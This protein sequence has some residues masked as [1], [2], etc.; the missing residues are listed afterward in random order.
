MTRPLDRHL[1]GDEV[2]ALVTSQATGVPVAGQLSEGAIREAQRHVEACQDCDRKVQMHRSVQKVIS[3]RAMGDQKAKG[4]NCSDESEWV[5]VA[6]GLF[7]E[8]EAKERMNHAAQCGH[9]GPLLKFAVKALSDETTPDEEV[10]LANLGS[11]GPEW[12]AQIA[13]TLR[14]AAESQRLQEPSLPFWKS[15]SYWPRPA[16]AAAALVILAAG[17][18]VGVRILHPP[19]AEQLLAQAYSERRTLEVRI[20]GAKYAPVRTERGNGQSNL[21]RPRSLLRAEDLI[22]ENLGKHPDDPYWLQAKGRADL[23]DGN[24]DSAIESL[25]KVADMRP[26]SPSAMIDLASA[27][28]QRG[29]MNENREADYGTA[30]D[31]LGRVLA[32]TPSD[33]I[34]L[35][36]RAL[37][38][39]KL[40]LYAPAMADWQHY[41]QIQPSDPWAPEARRHLES[42]QERL[43]T[44]QSSL[45]KPLLTANELAAMSGSPS[46]ANELDS[47]IED[48]L[49]VAAKDWFLEACRSLDSQASRKAQSALQALAVVSRK[50]HNDSWLVDLMGDLHKRGF[51][52]GARDLAAAVSANENGDYAA[53]QKAAQQAGKSFQD[54]G[55][56][57]GELRANVEELYADHLLYDGRRCLSLLRRMTP[58]LDERAYQWIRAQ[59]ALEAS[60]CFD[61]VGDPGTAKKQLDRG[62]QEAA[63]HGYSNLLLRGVGF[64]A[65]LAAY[66]GDSQTGFLLAAKGLDLFWSTPVELM[67][68]Y[69]LYTDLDT[70]ADVEHLPF[71]QVTLW[72]QATALIDLHPDIVQR[73]MAHR[74][75]ANSAYLAN[76]PDLAEKQFAQASAL[77]RSAPPTEATARGQME[78]E[79]WLA[80]LEVRQGDFESAASRLE[81]VQHN[82]ESAPS[83]PTEIA[84]YTTKAQLS[85]QRGEN[86][87]AE[88]ALRSSI[89]L[90]EWALQSL[91]GNLSR[92]QWAEHTSNAYRSL[93]AWK[94]HLGDAN[95]ALEFWEWYTGAEFRIRGEHSQ[96][97]TDL[98]RAV[99]PNAREAPPLVTPDAVAQQLPLM[100]NETVVTYAVFSEGTEV[101]AFD[102]RGIASHWIPR[103]AVDLAEL[104]LRFEHLCSEPD[105]SIVAV[106]SAAQQLY[107]VLVSPVEDRILPG[108][109]LVFELDGAL[110]DVP[111]EALVDR[112]GRYLAER[113]VIVVSPGLYQT[114]RLRPVS[115]ISADAP[116]LVVSVSAPPAKG[117]AASVDT[118]QEAEDVSTLFRSAVWLKGRAATVSA[119][120]GALRSAHVFHFAGHAVALPERNGLLLAE[121]DNLTEQARLLN[122]EDTDPSTLRNL[123]LAVLSACSTGRFLRP[124]AS[125][126]ESLSQFLIR[127]GV[128]HVIA[129]RWNVDSPTTALFMKQF[130]GQLLKGEDVGSSLHGAE[131]A[132]AAEV[133]FTHPYYWAPFELKGSAM[134]PSEESK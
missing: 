78:A 126:T 74:W 121:R 8:T 30:I 110:S 56:P 92:H 98:D 54:A 90:A 11:A 113:A 59:T 43:K 93:V 96:T 82:Q 133:P 119:I 112:Q 111:F 62:T 71:L 22:A 60:N 85:L 9:C 116:A 73:A 124:G 87:N 128:P 107:N 40:R 4:P 65:D 16:F 70:A 75:Y 32:R 76:M 42:V 41:L 58:Y 6:A 25:Q 101:W 83:F 67:K 97:A 2:D 120:D 91:S 27:Y 103:P 7:R 109:T 118:E 72:N 48:Y 100:R 39:E 12:Q 122:A 63:D 68:G 23:L 14:K 80:G 89:Y 1:D 51:A 55:S 36:N 105:S 46:V 84:F 106:R 57:A 134:T 81:R 77:F 26:D 29:A 61:L 49:H 131:L 130:Y 15:L 35:F 127:A 31:Y 102:D 79:I 50:Q 95:A 64:Q 66:L 69:N 86:G 117:F 47:R 129:S 5:K 123:Q 37:A 20:E 132:L 19:S 3:Q 53:A 44:K 13:R 115:P 38:E 94:L 114:L 104:A 125:G 17:T 10:A 18:W 34:A 108:R 33:P 99:P 28:Y 21:D 24:Y 52:D 45:N 88:P